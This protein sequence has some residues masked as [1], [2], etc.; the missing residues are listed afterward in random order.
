YVKIPKGFFPQQ[1]TGMLIGGIQADQS[2][3][4]QAMKLKFTEMMKI[5][6][7]DPNVATVAGFSGGRATNTGF[8]FITLKDKPGRKLSADQVIA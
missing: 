7:S 1:D 6:Q 8:M 5:A 3:S 2:T 4:F